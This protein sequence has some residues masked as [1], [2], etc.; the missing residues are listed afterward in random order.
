[1]KAK[2]FI[3]LIFISIISINNSIAEEVNANYTL[4]LNILGVDVKIG[5]IKSK[6]KIGSDKY[7]LS[8]TIESEKLI[9]FISQINGDGD[10]F[11]KID[12]SI[13]T[14]INYEYTYTK[15]NKIK[16]TEIL[17]NNSNVI[18]SSTTPSF[19]KDK[20][21]P[22]H[23]NALNNVIDP[24]TGIIY[25]SDY[26]LNN[27]CNIKY[28]IYDGKRR[29]DL[30]YTDKF[31][32]NGFT[33]CRLSQKKIGGFKLKDQQNTTFEPAHEIDTYFKKEND[34]YILKKIVSKGRFSNILIDVFYD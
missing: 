9:G 28:K 1:M 33:I 19:D 12:N 3:F 16:N 27:G 18:K 4:S 31:Y 30:D 26:I 13:L 5:E 11:G 6:L 15:K 2:N 10:V 8:F 29:Y 20:L 24:I 7:Q 25:I 32:K 23:K 34:R 21:S 14:P 22:I 17:F